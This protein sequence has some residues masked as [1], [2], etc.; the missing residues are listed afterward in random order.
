[1]NLLYLQ[2]LCIRYAA[3]TGVFLLFL[4]VLPACSRAQGPE[5]LSLELAVR[6]LPEEQ[7]LTG[8][9]IA[10]LPAGP[11][12]PVV[13]SLAPR[14]RVESVRSGPSALRH[15]LRDG[16]LTVT[17]PAAD[18]ER[19]VTIGYAGRFADRIPTRIVSFEDPTYGVSGVITPEGTYLSGD[20]GWYPW[21]VTDLHRLTVRVAA[22]PGMEA[23]TQGERTAHASDDRETSSTWTVSRP[24][25][26]LALSAGPYRIHE[27]QEGGVTLY[28]YFLPD[29]EPLSGRYLD[30]VAGYL[31]LYQG[32]F[33]RYPFPKFA[34]VENFLPTG[35]GYPSYT[36]L[37]SGVIRLPFILETSL[38]HEL[39][40]CWWGNGVQVDLARGNW[41]EGLA[42][43]LADH[44]VLERKGERE[45]RE[46]RQRLVNDYAA[47]VG[48]GQ[49]FPLRTFRGRSD[50]ASR[51]IGYG[52]AAMLFHM[53]RR[54][55]GDEA[56]FKGLRH[57][58]ETRLFRT[59]SWDDL[60]VAFSQAGGRDLAPFVAQ[61]LDR[62]GGPE[63]VLEKVAVVAGDARWRVTGMVRQT[64]AY[65][66]LNVTMALETDHGVVR[67]Q[68]PLSGDATAFS[69]EVT[70]P[71]RR[72]QLDPDVDLFRV[73][74]VAELPPTVNRLKGSKSLTV[75]VAAGQSQ[76]EPLQTL[77]ASLGQGG[78]VVVGEESLGGDLPDGDFL[79]YGLPGRSD[80]LGGLPKGLSLTSG[81]FTVG[82]E[83]YDTPADALLLVTPH[84]RAVDRVR[85]L[86][87][88][89]SREA[90]RLAV[91]KITHYG[92]YGL[93]VFRGGDN[94]YKGVGMAPSGSTVVN[95]AAGG[96]P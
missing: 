88:P 51:A 66:G 53:I 38:P 68:L 75:V 14:V 55:I 84:P 2:R 69:L 79:I 83:R 62:P 93:L 28:T 6:L 1:M 19:Q 61:W 52:K 29:N 25:G 64:P 17:L 86:F 96:V 49:D 26:P 78:A 31:R 33:G 60:V 81:G 27:R 95:L 87:V 57:V 21:P 32:L 39:A 74:P 48:P 4:L 92:R 54:T 71:P 73:V 41:S 18:R 42:T 94:R 67:R 40:H 72:L 90:A 56:F 59:A 43:Y 20:A 76:D 80:L 13:F 30:A 3:L 35:Y 34:V 36:L 7:R 47:L 82:G 85:G 12:T 65:S 37:G 50:P 58:V 63:L 44:L 24:N 91:S 23:I 5:L 15:T 16:A 45:A 8:T 89:R 77:L 22:P 9:A 10:T 11:E 46:Y 70:D